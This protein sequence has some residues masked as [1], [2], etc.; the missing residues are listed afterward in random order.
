[1]MLTM[2]V[3]DK[4]EQMFLSKQRTYSKLT[5]LQNGASQSPLLDSTLSKVY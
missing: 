5:Q 1:M 2:T 4:D 3:E